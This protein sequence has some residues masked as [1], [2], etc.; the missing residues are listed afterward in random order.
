MESIQFF[1]WTCLPCLSRLEGRSWASS[2]VE[3]IGPRARGLGPS[4]LFEKSLI[5]REVVFYP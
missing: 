2:S 3:G 5:E 1:D 4:R